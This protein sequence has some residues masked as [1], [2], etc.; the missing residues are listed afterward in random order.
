MFFLFIYTFYI[1]TKDPLNALVFYFCLVYG[2]VNMPMWTDCSNLRHR[3]LFVVL[4]LEKNLQ[5]ITLDSYLYSWALF[6]FI[7]IIKIYETSL[8]YG[9][10]SICTQQCRTTQY[11]EL[12]KFNV[13]VWLCAS[14]I[15]QNEVQLSFI[16]LSF[17]KYLSIVSEVKDM[18]WS[19]RAI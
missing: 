19:C 16:Q 5:E 10:R 1:F 12:P 4:L 9:N 18:K 15:T 8:S 13:K 3:C 2:V 6:F 7:V 17:Y 11:F 14:I